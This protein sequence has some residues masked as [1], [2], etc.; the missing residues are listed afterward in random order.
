MKIDVFAGRKRLFDV[1][2]LLA[3]EAKGESSKSVMLSPTNSLSPLTPPYGL[4][5]KRFRLTDD[6]CDRFKLPEDGGDRSLLRRLHNSGGGE[7]G[8]GD[9][10]ISVDSDGEDEEEVDVSGGVDDV[11][12][13]DITAERESPRNS[14]LRKRNVSAMSGGSM[15]PPLSHEREAR[16]SISSSPSGAP[17]GGRAD[18]MNINEEKSPERCSS[19]GDQGESRGSWLS[20]P[21][22]SSLAIPRPS[23]AGEG[24]SKGQPGSSIPGHPI[25]VHPSAFRSTGGIV[26]PST[27]TAWS[28]LPPHGYPLMSTPYPAGGLPTGSPAAG[29]SPAEAAAAAQRWQ[30]AFSRIVQRSYDAS[31]NLKL[32]A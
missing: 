8:D 15:T 17:P 28:S 14:L 23:F 21:M 2:S 11:T 30:E 6:R 24:S 32:E 12:G 1:E 20:P 22:P 3:P 26:H 16:A 13:S 5:H 18:S 4:P 9:V 25:V 19:A 31:K 27:V 7:S 10:R 29:V